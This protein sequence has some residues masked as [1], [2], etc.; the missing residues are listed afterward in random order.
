MNLKPLLI[1]PPIVLGIAG[2]IWMTGAEDTQIEA[3]EPTRTAVRVMTIEAEPLTVTATGYGRVEAEHTWTAVSQV[4]GRI[5]D[6]VDNLAEGTLVTEGQ[7]LLQVDKTDFELA[8]QKSE[9]NIAAA[10][11][12]LAELERR[13]ANSRRSLEVEERIYAVAQA[14]FKRVSDL[15]GRGTSTRA[16]LDTAQKTLLAQETSVTNLSNTLALYPAQRAAAEAT[17][18]VRRAELAEAKRG[19]ENTTIIAPF[20]GRISQASVETGQFVRTGEQLLVLEDTQAVEVIGAFQ[21]NVFSPVVQIAVGDRFR[22]MITVES[23][24]MV[25]YLQQAGVRASVRMQLAEFDVSFPAELV[26]FRGTIDSET[27]TV[28]MAVRV[29]NPLQASGTQRRPPLNVGS[30][31]S[32]VLSIEAPEGAI[33]VPRDALHYSDDGTPFLYTVNAKDQLA[34]TFVAPGPIMGEK[35][36]INDGLRA[37]DRVVLSEPRPPI[38]GMAL[39]QVPVKT[40][41]TA[42]GSE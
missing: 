7:L 10:E 31:V 27:G 14:E 36:G 21:P 5:V 9:A 20:N 42:D 34:R 26:R 13:E 32:V 23:S 8:I 25:D 3:R 16:A 37:G 35:I 38:E 41:A 30:F 11:A 33:A 15:E 2:F 6:L 18:A 1:L 4:D 17:L 28:G 19:L 12:S 39:T 22:D 24:N 40:V 29:E